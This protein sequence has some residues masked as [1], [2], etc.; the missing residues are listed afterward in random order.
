MRVNLSHHR[1]THGGVEPHCATAPYLIGMAC[2]S[3][4]T[5]TICPTSSIPVWGIHLA[6]APAGDGEPEEPP[7]KR[8]PRGVAKGPRPLLPLVRRRGVPGETGWG[9]LTVLVPRHLSGHG[10]ALRGNPTLRHLNENQI[11]RYFTQ[12]KT[13]LLFRLTFPQPVSP[14]STSELLVS[15]VHHG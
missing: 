4:G 3:V 1:S 5:P 2:R 14:T 12:N 6:S 8:T 7:P 11:A 9:G 10:W 15:D 13:K